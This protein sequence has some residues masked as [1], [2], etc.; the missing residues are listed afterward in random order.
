[1]SA[2]TRARISAAADELGYRPNLNARR[3]ASRRSGTLGVMLTDLHNPVYAEILDGIADEDEPHQLLLATGFRDRARERAGMGF[4][5]A[6]QVEGILVAGSLCTN[7]EIRHLAKQVPVVVIG[8][9]VSDVDSVLVDD[10]LGLRQ[11]VEHLLGLGHEG[12]AHIDGGRGAGSA[13]RR[14]SYQDTMSAH[15]LEARMRVEPGDY[16]E[17]GGRAAAERLLTGSDRPTAI[18]AANDLSAIGALAAAREAGVDVPS[19]LSVVGYDNTALAHNGYVDLSTV[20]Y[21]RDVMGATARRLLSE[22]IAD[23]SINPARVVTVTTSLIP[24][25]TSAP[26]ATRR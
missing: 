20:D 14:R 7:E 1:V 8:R 11:A 23:P 9:K 19:A 12:I 10:A 3:L 25:S 4:L 24:R 22:R 5:V 17:Q 26:P 13:R 15:G 16:T 21:P 6:Q 2:A 18:V